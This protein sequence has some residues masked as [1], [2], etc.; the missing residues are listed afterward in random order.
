MA[1]NV[2]R[3]TTRTTKNASCLLRKAPYSNRATSWFRRFLSPSEEKELYLGITSSF[4]EKLV[5]QSNKSTQ[6]YSHIIEHAFL[7]IK[8]TKVTK[9]GMLTIARIE[10]LKIDLDTAGKQK[11]V[12]KLQQLEAEMDD[13][14]LKTVT[15]YNRLIRS[16]LWSNSVDLAH[17]VLIGFD[18]RGL[19]PT[20]RSY[21]YLVQAYLKTD[22]L[23]HAKALVEEMKQSSLLK[24][25]NDFDYNIILNFYKAS[26][27]THAID[28]LWR[29]VVLHIDTIKPSNSLYIS[30]LEHL[31]S[32][33]EIK[34]ISQLAQ[35]YLTHSP[36]ASLQLHQYITW[37]KAV[38]LLA[39]NKQDTYKSERL[40]LHLIKK[41]P[42][43]TSWD[44]AKSGISTIVTSYLNED[45]ELKALA[46]Y[47]RLGKMG[48]P[49]QAFEPR[50]VKAI[51][52]VVKKVEQDGDEKAIIAELEGLVISHI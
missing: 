50:T 3:T 7:G 25:R 1:H 10:Q 13:A 46:F 19:V 21:I 4:R 17:Q 9:T 26:G 22:Q 41:A 30:Y 31:L 8:S 32:K 14:D 52:A 24:L 47:Y 11:D 35:E 16:Y 40:L 44:K 2:L 48:V 37:M 29:D 15:I 49:V 38:T 6:T 20:A 18:Q 12:K 45:Q 39:K 34:P 36:Q 27:D 28:F 23:S 51:E 33:Q 42:P 43:K 5:E